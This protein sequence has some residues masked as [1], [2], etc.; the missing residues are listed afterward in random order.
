GRSP[1]GAQR[2]V[3]LVR[4]ALLPDVGRR[5]EKETGFHSH[6]YGNF[7]ADRSRWETVPPTP[8]YGIHYAGLRNRVAVLSESYTYAPFKDRVLG[9]RAFVKSICEYAA[10]NKD[11]IAKV[12]ADAR[13]GTTRAGKEPK[14]DDKFVLRT[15]PAPLCRPHPFL[16]FAEHVKDCSHVTTG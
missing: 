9:S 7:S 8:R 4:D 14:A 16:G 6:F 12:L 3:A 15:K 2:V 1:A 10:E 5:L 13:E 11:K